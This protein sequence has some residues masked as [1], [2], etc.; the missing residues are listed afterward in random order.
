MGIKVKQNTSPE[1]HSPFE[2]GNFKVSRQPGSFQKQDLK[3]TI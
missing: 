2:K 3:N 1:A